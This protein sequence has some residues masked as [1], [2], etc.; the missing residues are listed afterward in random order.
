MNKCFKCVYISEEYIKTLLGLN[1]P[2]NVRVKSIVLS[3]ERTSSATIVRDNKNNII[4]SFSCKSIKRI[5]TYLSF[6]STKSE[7]FT[8]ETLYVLPIHELELDTIYTYDK[9]YFISYPSAK[10]VDIS[11]TYYYI[12]RDDLAELIIKSNALIFNTNFIDS[13]QYKLLIISIVN[14]RNK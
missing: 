7:V 4:E 1:V 9:E 2:N 14:K 12:N 5:N 11:K 3:D 8:I 10:L 6:Y 13:V